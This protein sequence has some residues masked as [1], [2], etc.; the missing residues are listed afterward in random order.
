MSQH[1][2]DRLSIAIRTKGTPTCVG[3]DPVYDRLPADITAQ[4]GLDD[5]DDI[6]CVVDAV[7][8]YCRHVIKIVAPLVPAVKI[9]IAFFEQYHWDG[10]E[11]YHELVQEARSRGLIVIGDVKRADIGHS[12]AMYARAH[13]AA[14]ELGEVEELMI[15]DAITVNPY[16][17]LDGVKPFIDAA[18][19]NDKGVFVLVQTS[20]ETAAELQGQELAGGGTVAEHV[21]RLVNRWAGEPALMGVSGYSAIGA[22]AAPRDPAA[23]ARLR[24][25]M[26][27]CIFLVPGFGAQG[28]GGDDVKPCFKPDGTGALVTASRSVIYAYEDTK[29]LESYASEWE[30][31]VEHAC[32]DFVKSVASVI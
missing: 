1:F 11:A 22:V 26:P 23:M 15:P 17:G 6:E 4:D 10:L 5:A 3:I 20:N 13:L 25:M 28:R 9:N 31:C 24:A 27:N 30:K 7:T 32:R 12:S 18:D 14:P 29:Y 16:F 2:A 19:K 21:G 8:E